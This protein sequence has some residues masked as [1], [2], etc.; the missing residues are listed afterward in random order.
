MFIIFYLLNLQKNQIKK[1]K[2][3][4]VA[5]FFNND[6]CQTFNN[7]FLYINYRIT[8]FLIMITIILFAI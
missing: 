1:Y 3:Y 5:V 6:N 2:K 7:N 8:N 4:K